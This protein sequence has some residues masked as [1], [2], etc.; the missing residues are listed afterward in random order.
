[1]H[2]ITDKG[3]IRGVLRN[4]MLNENRPHECL[5]EIRPVGGA[6]WNGL[7][8]SQGGLIVEG[9]RPISCITVSAT[10]E[11]VFT[12]SNCD[13]RYMRPIGQA[14]LDDITSITTL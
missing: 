4:Y 13:S 2:T 9:P 11:Q 6:M 5:F 7:K 10:N 8:I 14:R 3:K 12:L 1:M